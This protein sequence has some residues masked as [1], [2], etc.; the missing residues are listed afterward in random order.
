MTLDPNLL[1]PI[2]IDVTSCSNRLASCW[3]LLVSCFV[4]I[5]RTRQKKKETE[6]P[7]PENVQAAF[8]SL[9]FEL[10]DPK[11]GIHVMQDYI[12]KED[13]TG[14]LEFTKTY[15]LILRKQ[16]WARCKAFFE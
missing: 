15:D 11:G 16:K 14:L 1:Q 6:P 8:A 5:S 4:S 9:E 13:F 2:P 3:D 12:D 7:T 10:N